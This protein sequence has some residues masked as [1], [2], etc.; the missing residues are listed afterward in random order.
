[1]VSN[2]SYYRV[3]KQGSTKPM[4][5]W[6]RATQTCRWAIRN[7]SRW[8]DGKPQTSVWQTNNTY[9]LHVGPP[10]ICF[11]PVTF[12]STGPK[13]AP[14][15]SRNVEPFWRHTPPPLTIKRWSHKTGG[16]Q[17]QDELYWNARPAARYLR[18]FKTSGLLWQWA[19]KSLERPLTLKIKTTHNLDHFGLDNVWF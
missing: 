2:T 1:M 5:R 11:R 6:P 14:I 3:L 10:I 17:W 18:S 12:Y 8:P 9:I 16:L 19:L 15:I 4:A 13:G 7:D